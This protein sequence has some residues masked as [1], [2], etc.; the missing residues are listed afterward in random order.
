MLSVI[1]IIHALQTPAELSIAN[2][3]VDRAVKSN[4]DEDQMKLLSSF[5][6]IDTVT[7][8]AQ[9]GAPECMI[10][11]DTVFETLGY[12][13]KGTLETYVEKTY[14]HEVVETVVKGKMVRRVAVTVTVFKSLCAET[15]VMRSY[16]LAVENT[17]IALVKSGPDRAPATGVG[18][19]AYDRLQ[20]L[21]DTCDRLETETTATR[22]ECADLLKEVQA[23]RVAN[24]E[25]HASVGRV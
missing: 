4:M 6:H 18:E 16:F 14:P 9:T 12:K 13:R 20:W 3:G 15:E 8:R 1:D 7:E 5:V 22:S 2:D 24:S 10:Y 19:D 23:L 21:I 25:M 11:L 17:L